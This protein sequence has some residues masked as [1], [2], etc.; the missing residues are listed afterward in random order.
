MNI[1]QGI[2]YARPLGE[3]DRCRPVSRLDRAVLVKTLAAF[4]SRM[5]TKTTHCAA[6][7]KRKREGG[8]G[9]EEER[10]TGMES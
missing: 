10:D 5:P 8:R 4:P 3:T 7:L 2:C 6:A 1:H 9:R